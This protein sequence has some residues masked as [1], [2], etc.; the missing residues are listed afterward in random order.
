MMM[1][2][3]LKS[4]LLISLF[5]SFF[6]LFMRRTTFFRFNRVVLLVGSTICLTLPLI[7]FDF[8]PALE[9]MYL[10][11]LVLPASIVGSDGPSAAAA[12]GSWSWK[13]FLTLVY[14]LGAEGV[15]LLTVASIV[16]TVIMIRR[17]QKTDFPDLRLSVV[18][19]DMPSFSFLRNVVMSREDFEQNPM[20]LTHERAHVHSL[21]SVDLLLF[22]VVLALQWFNPLVWIMRTELKML[23][24]YEADEAVINQGIDAKLYQLLLVKKAVGAQRFQMANGFNH[25]K[26]KNRITMMQSVKS[27]NW[28]RLGYVACVPVLAAALCFCTNKSNSLTDAEDKAYE[29]TLNYDKVESDIPVEVKT[30][31]KEIDKEAIPFQ[32][33]DVQPTFNGGDANAFAK[34]VNTNLEYPESAKEANIQGRV[35]CQFAIDEEGNLV[36]AQIIR[37]VN[38]ALDNEALRVLKMSPKWKPGILDGKPVKVSFAFP[39][40]YRLQ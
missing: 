7:D 1:A 27:S 13:E 36:D 25:T 16:K 12:Q 9:S 33:V 26:L 10:P 15:V 30:M 34:W 6:I 29:A 3:I 35:M 20:I 2:Y 40:I 31:T 37:G 19:E 8:G 14:I 23:H 24:E 11:R 5:Y 21:H 28:L 39:I 32:L 38:E 4:G 22:S 18:E 17:G